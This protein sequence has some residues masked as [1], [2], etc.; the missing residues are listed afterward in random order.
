M[1][2][3][4]PSDYED[5]LYHCKDPTLN[6]NP[7]RCD[8]TTYLWDLGDLNPSEQLD[9]SL[10]CQEIVKILVRARAEEN[11]DPGQA[12]AQETQKEVQLWETIMETSVVDQLEPCVLWAMSFGP[13]TPYAASMGLYDDRE[14]PPQIANVLD[15]QIDISEEPDIKPKVESV[16]EAAES[17]IDIYDKPA[18]I[19]DNSGECS[20]Y[21]VTC[22]FR[23]VSYIFIFIWL[24]IFYFLHRPHLDHAGNRI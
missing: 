7:I 9:D 14:P 1:A 13:L 20:T 10:L 21:A 3:E 24:T 17:T 15:E 19:N 6:Q 22:L 2:D 23:I 4:L 12:Q 18:D 11:L 5:D 8:P 16:I